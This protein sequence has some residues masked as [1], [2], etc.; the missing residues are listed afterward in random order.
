VYK[1]FLPVDIPVG[2]GRKVEELS[3]LKE[4]FMKETI[5]VEVAVKE[6]DSYGVGLREA[7]DRAI[8]KL[9]ESSYIKSL[10]KLL[11]QMTVAYDDIQQM[12]HRKLE[13]DGIRSDMR[14][15]N[16]RVQKLADD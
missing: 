7:L 15:L 6:F 8:E 3:D 9:T 16:E 13:V 12:R 5:H 10:A 14:E 4:C 2:G 11:N 1:A